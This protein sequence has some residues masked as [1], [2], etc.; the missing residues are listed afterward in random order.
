MIWII[1]VVRGTGDGGHPRGGRCGVGRRKWCGR[2]GGGSETGHKNH[3]KDCLIDRLK[4]TNQFGAATCWLSLSLS[5]F[6]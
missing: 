2:F 6:F 5:G 3:L 1:V 4:A